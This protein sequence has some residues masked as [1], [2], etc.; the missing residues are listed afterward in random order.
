MTQAH[1]F[2]W[3]GGIKGWNHASQLLLLQDNSFTSINNWSTVDDEITGDLHDP[4][5]VQQGV[6]RA[7]GRWEVQEQ[8]NNGTVIRLIPDKDW[9]MVTLLVHGGLSDPQQVELLTGET[10][11]HQESFIKNKLLLER[12][13]TAFNEPQFDTRNIKKGISI[14]KIKVHLDEDDKF[15]ESIAI[16][17]A[18]GDHVI[19]GNLN[20]LKE[21]HVVTIHPQEQLN[22]ISLGHTGNSLFHIILNTN[23]RSVKLGQRS[24]ESEKTIN[25]EQS[26]SL[27]GISGGF[28][29][30]HIKNVEFYTSEIN[31]TTSPSLSKD[32]ENVSFRVEPPN[33]DD[34]VLEFVGSGG[35]IMSAIGVKYNSNSRMP[36]VGGDKSRAV[37]SNRLLPGESVVSVYI[38]SD[39]VNVI[40][41]GIATNLNNLYVL[42][43]NEPNAWRN[44]DVFT[45]VK[46]NE[47]EVMVGFEGSHDQDC[48]LTSVNVL[49]R[50]GDKVVTCS[51]EV[52]SNGIDL[53]CYKTIQ[54]KNRGVHKSVL[55][56]G[57]AGIAPGEDYRV[58]P[59][60][61]GSRIVQF[62]M[63][64]H[65]FA[66][67][68]LSL[69]YSDSEEQI[70]IGN[71]D[72]K[73]QAVMRLEEDEHLVEARGIWN[74]EKII[75]LILTTDKAN[76]LETG[77]DYG[78]DDFE[79]EAEKGH[80]IIGFCGRAS[81]KEIRTFGIITRKINN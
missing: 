80:E 8:V 39:N 36:I 64:H 81:T 44:V 69:I 34:K 27:S 67:T 73:R 25:V 5:T 79:F 51:D 26:H 68:S 65:K 22:S 60:T 29:R 15:I 6:H 35:R 62:G 11:E 1:L 2:K 30:G 56:E 40:F 31:G 13:V 19:V 66:H 28:T 74:D 33:L 49:A 48:L 9:Q 54:G 61:D 50:V 57:V 45:V 55:T 78:D 20:N 21:P 46:I 75:Y 37:L 53:S 10:R 32:L 70:I 52:C 41:V 77:I 71:H 16:D 4:N 17:F 42:G 63:V 59:K 18:D 43:T 7:N 14:C 47:G 23:T 3:D 12:V 38:R 24:G 58:G 76:T 72:L